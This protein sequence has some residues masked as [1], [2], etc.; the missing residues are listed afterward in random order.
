MRSP[1]EQVEKAGAE[2]AREM[3]PDSRRKELPKEAQPFL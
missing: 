3:L 1:T 2:K